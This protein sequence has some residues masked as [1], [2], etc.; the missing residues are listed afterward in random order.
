MKTRPSV[1]D[2]H[3]LVFPLKRLYHPPIRFRRTCTYVFAQRPPSRHPGIRA[4]NIRDPSIRIPM[5][6][7]QRRHQQNLQMVFQ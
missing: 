5:R 4:A 1:M 7:H 3:G 2:F 6:H